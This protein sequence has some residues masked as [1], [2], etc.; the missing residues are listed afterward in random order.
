MPSTQ[1]L[2]RARTV[3]DEVV[4]RLAEGFTPTAAWYTDPAVHELERDAVFGRIWQLV[5]ATSD[6]GR[7][8]DYFVTA[9]DEFRSFIVICGGDG[10]L[11][12]FANT[13]PH[14]GTE[15]LEGSGCAERIRCPYHAWAFDLAGKLT[16]VPGLKDMRDVDVERYG[17]REAKVDT[18]GPFVF[19][20]P[21]PAAGPLADHLGTLPEVM[22]GY[23]IDLVGVSEQGNALRYH[24]ILECNWKI[25]VENALECYHCPTVHPGFKA[26]V[27]LPN[28]HIALKGQC[29]VQGTTLRDDL[30]AQQTPGKMSD[31]VADSA[32]GAGG[33]DLAMFHWIFPNNSVS[34]WPGPANSFN[35]ARWV[36]LGPDRCRWETIRWWSADVPSAVRDAQWNFIAEVGEEDHVIVE[37][38]QRGMK[39]GSWA[40]GPFM[41]GR[42][43]SEGIDNDIRDE[44]G[45]HR[46]NSI[47]AATVASFQP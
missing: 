47:T 1:Q 33:S 20:N 26:T 7:P 18:W 14:R 13:C 40:G 3:V 32:Y 21:D 24:G 11:R 46:F 6:V 31:L 44:R 41:L 16:G 39:S 2:E 17:L 19:L 38:V 36:P 45:P 4:A 43:L 5:G 30:T 12:A 37:R 28:W 22:S 8:G 10:R 25:A 29:V 15:L 42:D 34:L 23:G 9:V 35:F 27:D